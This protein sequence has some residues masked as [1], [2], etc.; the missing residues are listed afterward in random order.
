MSSTEQGPG[1]DAR[2]DERSPLAEGVNEA[3]ERLLTQG[4]VGTKGVAW[5]APCSRMARGRG[6]GLRRR[7]MVAYRM[8]T[9]LPEGVCH[10]AGAHRRRPRG[11]G[12]GE[13]VRRRSGGLR[14]LRRARAG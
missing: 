14:G 9:S 4:T 2:A 1:D 13:R 3:I 10:G 7:C 11:D 12:R 5:A 6:E 8:I